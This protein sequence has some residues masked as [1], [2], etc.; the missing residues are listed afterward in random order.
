MPE[1]APLYPP[2]FT[3]PEQPLGLL[4]FLVRCAENPLATIPID[5]Y[6][7]PVTAV[8]PVRG[9]RILW[10]SDPEAIETIL[11]GRAQSFEKTAVERRVFE[12]VIGNGV[13][14]AEGSDWRWQRRLLAPLF[15][16]SEVLGY[17]PDMVAAAEEVIGSWRQ[18]ASSGPLTM[19][20]AIDDDM[21][22]ATYAVIVR[23]ML[24]GGAPG[25]VDNVMECGQA[26]LSGTPWV[27]AYGMLNL[28]S[29]LPHPATFKLRR[30]A[31]AFRASV[32][33]IIDDRER[34]GGTADDLLG[35]LMAARDPETEAPLTKDQLVD[36]VATLLEAGHETTAKTLTWALY[37]L[38]RAPAWQERIRNE[39]GDVAGDAPMT[40]KHIEKLAVTERVIKEALRLYPPAPIMGRTPVDP[41]EVA[42]YELRPGHQVFVPIYAVH[43]HELLWEDPGRFDPDRF[44]PDR[45]AHIRRAQYM[46]FGAGPRICLGAAFAM[47]EAK[48]LLASFVRRARFAWDGRHLPEP[49]SRVTL[50]PKGGMP[51][52]VT[53]L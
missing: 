45:E 3:P 10:F 1:T 19:T 28:P 31:K 47:I 41:V 12:P 40:A 22:Q 5:A 44:L 15:R 42:G 7:R 2:T 51:L 43:R 46:P 26:Y 6:R 25:D 13:L 8:E 14:T 24:F 50:H 23:T 34:R 48:T 16:P 30:A 21:T 37:L 9:Q 18:S 27:L 11:V 35:R 52:H 29:W 17:V 53:L 20:R 39:V 32:R 4:Q 36:N 49:V 38:A 33:S